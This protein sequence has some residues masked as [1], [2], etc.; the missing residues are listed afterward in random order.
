MKREQSEDELDRQDTSETK[1]SLRLKDVI[2]VDGGS[3]DKTA[4]IA[5]QEG[6][7]VIQSLRGRA[8][9]L[10]KG[11]EMASGA[12][13]LL[14]LHGDCSLPRNWIRDMSKVID[15]VAKEK[16]GRDSESSP[17]CWGAFSD[18]RINIPSNMDMDAR[19]SNSWSFP[20]VRLRFSLAVMALGVKLR[21]ELFS[22]PYGD[23]AI[24]MTRDVFRY[25]MIVIFFR[26]LNHGSQS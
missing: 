7:T 26:S 19:I 14:F 4:S 13:V 25:E 5:R 21:T 3:H 12:D 17:S 2:L 16:K 10:N 18:V 6:A 22:L 11:G 8:S 1:T 15:K 23:Q 20:S 9:Q 24:W